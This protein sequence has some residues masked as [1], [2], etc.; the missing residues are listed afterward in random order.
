MFSSNDLAAL[1][2]AKIRS[3]SHLIV[4]GNTT[5]GYFAVF[6]TAA[7]SFPTVC[8][9]KATIDV[10]YWLSERAAVLHCSEFLKANA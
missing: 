4:E 8:R 1:E 6:E 7:G 2:A 5:D 3:R 9:H 10:D